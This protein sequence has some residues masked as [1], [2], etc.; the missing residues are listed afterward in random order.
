MLSSSS[1]AHRGPRRSNGLHAPTGPDAAGGSDHVWNL[2]GSSEWPTCSCAFAGALLGLY[3]TFLEEDA[4]RHY[5][6][7]FGSCPGSVWPPPCTIGLSMAAPVSRLSFPALSL[8]SVQSITNLM[9]QSGTSP[10]RCWLPAQVLEELRSRR[11]V[12][13]ASGDP[14]FL[15]PFAIHAVFLL[16]GVCEGCGVPVG[17]GGNDKGAFESCLRDRFGHITYPDE[18]PEGRSEPSYGL[19]AG[20]N[21]GYVLIGGHRPRPGSYEHL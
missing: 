8:W 1:E 19:R 9:M 21:G 15:V 6:S 14:I 3:L 10:Q 17:K 20:Q 12:W 4:G 13:S 5:L 11:I 18:L 2:E 7:S 16:Q